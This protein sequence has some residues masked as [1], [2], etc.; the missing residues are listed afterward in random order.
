MVFA[1]PSGQITL[2][3]NSCLDELSNG[4]YSGYNEKYSD[5]SKI[6]NLIKSISA[7]YPGHPYNAISTNMIAGY[8]KIKAGSEFVDFAL[9][10]LIGNNITLSQSIEGKIALRA[11]SGRR[12]IAEVA[13]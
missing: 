7:K 1:S 11:I 10:D 2:K 6:K 4:Y 12:L 9:P 13:K 5:L 8:E 3:P